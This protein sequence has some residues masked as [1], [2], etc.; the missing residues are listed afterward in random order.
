LQCHREHEL[1]LRHRDRRGTQRSMGG[2]LA[3]RP[4]DGDTE[5]VAVRVLDG[6]GHQPVTVSRDHL[7][8][9]H[10]SDLDAWAAGLWASL[11]GRELANHSI[12]ARVIRTCCAAS[13]TRTGPPKN[14]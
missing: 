4:K 10:I 7:G 13:S 8:A 3:Y 11:K 9:H 6:F 5:Q 2:R 14:R 12:R 1:L